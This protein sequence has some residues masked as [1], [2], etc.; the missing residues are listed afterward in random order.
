MIALVSM[1]AAATISIII[2]Y[3]AVVIIL[4]INDK[5]R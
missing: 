2:A 5:F 1:L 4:L 3:V